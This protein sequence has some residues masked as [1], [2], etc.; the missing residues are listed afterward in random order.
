MTIRTQVEVVVDSVTS[1]KDTKDEVKQ[2]SDGS[3]VAINVTSLVTGPWTRGLGSF[4]STLGKV[5]KL[6]M[7]VNGCKQAIGKLTIKYLVKGDKLSKLSIL[8]TRTGHLGSS[9]NVRRNK[10]LGAVSTTEDSVESVHG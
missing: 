9:S 7:S 1:G 3:I 5:L 10:G 6:I 8:G 4:D 2:G